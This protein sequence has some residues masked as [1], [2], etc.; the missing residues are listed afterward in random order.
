MEELRVRK[1]VKTSPNVKVA[2]GSAT[3]IEQALLDA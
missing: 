2:K 1:I 3:A